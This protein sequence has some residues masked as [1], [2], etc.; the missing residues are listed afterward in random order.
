MTPI[1]ALYVSGER[2]AAAELS[3]AGFEVWAPT[4]LKLRQRERSRS[5]ALL[6]EMPLFPGY[7][8]ARIAPERFS[9]VKACEHVL[10]V[11]AS[12]GFPAPIPED[13]FASMIV[14]VMSGRLNERLPSMRTRSRAARRRGVSGMSEWFE[15]LGRSLAA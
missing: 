7:V 4:Y 15:A 8:F 13:A 14:L 3:E 6:V 1:Y 9:H 10:S 12:D 2:K 11:L 5:L